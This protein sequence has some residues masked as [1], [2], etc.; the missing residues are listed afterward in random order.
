MKH[1]CKVQKVSSPST[2]QVESSVSLT[3]KFVW[4]L[5]NSN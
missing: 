2:S 1:Q 3:C 5:C 4:L